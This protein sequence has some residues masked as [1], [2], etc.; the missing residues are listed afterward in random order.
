MAKIAALRKKLLKE[1][2]S[3]SAK[4]KLGAKEQLEATR[5]GLLKL[6]A[7]RQDVAAIRRHL[8]RSKHSTTIPM[9]TE[10]RD[11][12]RQTRIGRSA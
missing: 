2:A 7:T 9:S 11:R 8:R 10:D 12:S 6:Q 4:L 1:Q 3:L 5:E